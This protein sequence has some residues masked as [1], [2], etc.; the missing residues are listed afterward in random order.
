MLNNTELFREYMRYLTRNL[1][2]LESRKAFCCDCTYAQCHTIL[3]IAKAGIISINDLTNILKINKSAT[4]RTVDELLNKGYV[5]R[6]QD[7]DDRRYV[8]IQLTDDG[9]KMHKQIESTSYQRFTMILEEIAEPERQKAIEGIR[10][11]A[12]AIQKCIAKVSKE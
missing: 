2:V 5:T 4:S 3:E 1:G 8:K 9:W 11:V 10:M 7:P 12:E 6:Q